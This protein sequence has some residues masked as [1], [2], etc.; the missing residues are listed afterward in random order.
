MS[1]PFDAILLA[2]ACIL[3]GVLAASARFRS[4][5]LSIRVLISGNLAVLLVGSAIHDFELQAVSGLGATALTA[6]L[7]VCV[8]AAAV[9]GAA[10]SLVEIVRVNR[11]EPS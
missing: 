3:I 9:I 6:T 10:R 4:D 2:T 7:V 1:G 11:Q 5:K 8:L